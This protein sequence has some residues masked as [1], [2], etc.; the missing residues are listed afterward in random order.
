MKP[1]VKFPDP[2]IVALGILRAEPQSVYTANLKFGT[3]DAEKRP[4]NRQ[5]L[6]YAKVSLDQSEGLYPVTSTARIRVTVWAKDQSD[7]FD[8]ASICLAVLASYPGDV[9]VRHLGNPAGPFHAPDPETGQPMAFFSLDA[10]LKPH[11]I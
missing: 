1:R 8:L 9:N 10:R 3:V 4:E 11:T 6:P 5:G 7:A 2:L